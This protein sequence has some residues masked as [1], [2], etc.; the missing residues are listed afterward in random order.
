MLPP[1]SATQIT[2]AKDCL[3][4]FAFHYFTDLPRPEA[5]PGAELGAKIHK[6][7]EDYL[8]NGTAPDRDTPEGEIFIGGLPWLPPPGS[9]GV[10]GRIDIEISHIPFTGFVD[11]CTRGGILPRWQFGPCPVV[12]DH[13]T[14]SDP[15]KWGLT[16][17][18]LPFDVQ[19][20]IYGFY[21][22]SKT[23][24]SE[25]GF[26]WLYYKTKGRPLVYPTDT[27]LAQDIIFKNFE[28]EVWPTAELIHGLWQTKPAP[29]TLE[30]SPEAC[31]KYGGCP[32]IGVCKLTPAEKAA[33]LM[34]LAQN[35]E[36]DMATLREKFEAQANRG[37]VNPPL[38]A[39]PAAS[40]PQAPAFPRQQPQI[41]N[42]A[43]VPMQLPLFTPKNMPPA[44]APQTSIAPP[45]QQMRRNCVSSIAPDGL[46]SQTSIA[47]P[48]QQMPSPNLTPPSGVS[49]VCG[50][51]YTPHTAALMGCAIVDPT[52]TIEARVRVAAALL[53]RH[54]YS[55]SQLRKEADKI[56]EALLK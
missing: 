11:L 27:V 29:N 40:T 32:Y 55:P 53:T 51:V 20:L 26:R 52:P 42:A 30:A 14:S 56:V 41:I 10:E 3:R 22:V 8:K 43:P 31:S 48:V 54:D 25:I 21:A 35:K 17:E 33:G 47:P 13:K 19:A 44:K 2:T 46:V 24:R 50:D 23:E 37:N 34:R 15:K 4:K 45:A 49:G 18:T 1:L 6:V 38:P 9:G 36:E 5:G 28:S 16:A 12:L 39:A 7:A